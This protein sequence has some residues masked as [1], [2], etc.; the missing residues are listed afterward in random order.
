MEDDMKKQLILLLALTLIASLLVAETVEEKL[1]KFGQENAKGFIQPFVNSFGNNLNSGFY[2]T[3]K[4]LKPLRFQFSLNLTASTIPS[5]DKTFM[6][7]NPFLND[8]FNP[9]I[10]TEI[11]TA[12]IFGKD[13]GEFTSNYPG[14]A[15]FAMPGGLDLK[16]MPFAVPQVS[17]GLPLGNEILVRYFPKMEINEDIGEFTFYGLG[18]KHS[19]SQYIPFF[20]VDVAVQGVMQK[21]EV[22]DIIKIDAVAANAEISKSILIFTL[23]GGLGFEKTNFVAEYS[24]EQSVFDPNDPANPST[25][26]IPVKLEL[27]SDNTMKT[28]IG[29]RLSPFPFVKIYGDYN[30]ANYNS[31]NAG[32]AIGF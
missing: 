29:L 31:L 19:I 27:E 13:G 11:E 21:M 6:V 5:S 26:T 3:A 17:V 16:M 24:F 4:V 7:Q 22:G 1:Q 10:E 9:Y 32:L 2:N 28:T 30:I 8:P 14:F 20:P 23:Y 18:L 25:T 12:T 15:P